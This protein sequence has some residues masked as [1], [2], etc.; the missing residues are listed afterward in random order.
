[1][2]GVIKGVL[3]QQLLRRKKGGRA[4]AVEVM[5]HEPA[6]TSLIREGKTNQIPGFIQ[7]GKT[8]GMIGMDDSLKKLV[9]DDVI[10]ADAALEK[11]IDKDKMREW[12]M[13]RGFDVAEHLDE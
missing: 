6:L 11:A 3:A 10:E 4:A 7:Q 5:F 8:R 2:A 12:L 13:D 9:D 1:M